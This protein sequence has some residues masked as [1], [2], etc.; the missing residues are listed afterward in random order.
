MRL[1]VG[2]G[3]PGSGYTNNRHNLG[4]MAVDAIAERHHFPPW[5]SKFQGVATDAQLGGDKAVLLKPS[6]FMNES[7]RSVAEAVKFY[8]LELDDVLVLFDEIE[9]APGKVRIKKGGGHAGHNGIRSVASHIGK[10]FWRVRL[11]VGH[12]GD[13]NRVSGYVLRDFAKSDASWVDAL[14]SAVAADADL[15]VKG[16]DNRFMTAVAQAMQ[17]VDTPPSPRDLRDAAEDREER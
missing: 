6:T 12:P 17:P 7:G 4:F 15:L 8:K 11:G 2:L 10:D 14:V 1:L 13:K 3:N 16:E 5:R 9:L